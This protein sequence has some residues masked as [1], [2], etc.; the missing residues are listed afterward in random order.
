MAERGGAL[1]AD[2]PGAGASLICG[3]RRV[4]RER[5]GFCRHPAYACPRTLCDD[6]NWRPAC[7][8]E[9]QRASQFLRAEV[10]ALKR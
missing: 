10:E 3:D 7:P 4:G 8:A 5:A 1:Y 9:A 2:E 6:Q